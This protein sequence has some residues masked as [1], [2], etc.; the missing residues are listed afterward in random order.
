MS[1]HSDLLKGL[2]AKK[3]GTPAN[4]KAMQEQATAMKTIAKEFR[5]SQVI[6]TPITKNAPRGG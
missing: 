1:A 5:Q 6:N 4:K 2:L 3:K